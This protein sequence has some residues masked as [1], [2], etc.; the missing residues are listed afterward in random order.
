MTDVNGFDE[1]API[2][3]SDQELEQ[4]AGGFDVVIT[5]VIA[6]QEIVVQQASTD[7][8]NGLSATSTSYLSRTSGTLF[9]FV[10]TGFSSMKDVFSIL[11]G[12]SRLFGR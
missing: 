4:I 3:L 2:E 8:S 12:F 6:E 7:L 11:S 10:G 9:Q 1:S 5:G